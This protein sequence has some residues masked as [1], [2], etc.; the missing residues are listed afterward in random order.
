MSHNLRFKDTDGGRANAGFKGRGTGD[1]VTRAIAIAL[2]LPYRRTYNELGALCHAMTGG[3]EK[4]V[5]D[6]V[7]T[8]VCHRFLLNRGWGITLTPGAYLKNIIDIAPLHYDATFI[9]V[10]ARH[11]VCVIDGVIHDTWDSRVS[12]RSKCGSP[13][14]IGYYSSDR[15]AR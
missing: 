10:L 14:L 5:R 6:G 13:R 3:I 15:S 11:Y 1:C 8:S 7:D 12:K 2:G 9:A 4:S